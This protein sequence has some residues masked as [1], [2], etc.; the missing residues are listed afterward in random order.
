MVM[1][2]GCPG[3]FFSSFFFV[4]LELPF[5]LLSSHVQIILLLRNLASIAVRHWNSG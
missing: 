5:L 4:A 1:Y 2:D 3:R